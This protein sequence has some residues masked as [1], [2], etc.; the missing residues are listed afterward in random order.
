M[1]KGDFLIG[2]AVGSAI[3]GAIALLCSPKS[4][5]ENRQ[6]LKDKSVEF[7]HD[8]KDVSLDLYHDTKLKVK[9]EVELLKNKVK[10]FP[11]FSLDIHDESTKPNIVVHNTT[12]DHS[13]S[14]K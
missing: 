2:L 8:I 12:N 4:G 13:V 14:T 5:S 9:E 3:G 7:S 6:Y 11:E 1:K 10:N